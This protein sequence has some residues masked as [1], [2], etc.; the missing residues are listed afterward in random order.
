MTI[1]RTLLSLAL[2]A[3]AVVALCGA[4]P[5]SWAVK[6]A[7]REWVRAHPACAVCGLKSIHGWRCEAHHVVPYHV[8]PGLGDSETNFVTLCRAHHWL[9]GHGGR[10]WS[11]ERT[12]VV[13]TIRAV[14]VVC[15]LEDAP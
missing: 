3:V 6:R 10:S 4:A 11:Y 9:V 14:R 8:A 1:R 5:R 2:V 13:E 15:G 12:N 7:Q